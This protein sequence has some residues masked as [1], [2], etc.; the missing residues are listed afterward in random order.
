MNE[1]GSK[2]HVPLISFLEGSK[3]IPIVDFMKNI[4]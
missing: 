1:K 2:E 3:L 4:S